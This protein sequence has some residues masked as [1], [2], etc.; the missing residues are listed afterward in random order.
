MTDNDTTR[1][2]SY[3]IPCSSTFRDS[4]S[5][6]A[7][8][9]GVNVA[10]LARSVTLVV[11]TKAIAGYPDPGEPE[12]GDRETVILKSGAAKGRPWRRKPRLQVRMSPG[13]DV[14]IIRRAL[15]LALAMDRG[16]LRVDVGDTRPAPPVPAPPPPPPPPAPPPPP[17]PPP[18]P[19]VDPARLQEITD[20]LERLQTIVSVLTFEPLPDGVQTRDDA[21][22]VLGLPPGRVPDRQT[23]R[24]RYRMLATIHHPDGRYGNHRR[25]SQLNEAMDVLRR[26][27]Y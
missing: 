21:L 24:A 3:T 17:P 19:T 12:A 23:L 14:L 18:V 5:D 25:M 2:H 11:P 20:E 8:R 10:D 7:R 4:V 6:L 13:Y 26:M 27:S 22:H 1:K 9:R 15:A 16:E